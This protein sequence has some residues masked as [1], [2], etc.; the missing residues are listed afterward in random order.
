MGGI[1]AVLGSDPA[2]DGP[3]QDGDE[4]RALDQGVAGGEL[5]AGEMVGKN[6]VLDRAEQRS[7]HAEQK[8]RHEQ[9][10]YR[11]HGEAEHCDEG[12][13]DLG[14]FEPPRHH[15]LV[16]AVR[17]FA[18]ERG[19]KEIGRDE[20]RGGKGDQRLRVRAADVE[21]NEKDQ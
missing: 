18:A 10:R 14:E 6:A 21:E 1:A 16:V 20:D 4:G 9:H 8:Q 15:R 3:K 2:D 5:G 13:A 19:Q 17:Q 11:M 7:D 12:N